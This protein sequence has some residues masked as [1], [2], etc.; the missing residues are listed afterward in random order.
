MNAVMQRIVAH[1]ERDLPWQVRVLRIDAPNAFCLPGGFIFFST[2]MLDALRSDAE[3][4]AIMAHEV[5]HVDKRHGMKQAARNQKLT[6]ASLAVIIATG[7]AGAPAI[8][9]QLAQTAITNS[10]GIEYEKQADKGGLEMLI[11]A[12]YPASAMVTVMEFFMSQEIKRPLYNYGIYM[13]H[14]E[15]VERVEYLSETIRRMNLP[16]ERKKALL[17]LRVRIEE[18]GDRLLL[19]VDEVKAWEG[20]NTKETREI[21]EKAREALDASFEMELA[22]YDLIV[23]EGDRLLR[24]ANRIVARAPLPQGTESLSSF[25]EKLLE[26]WN[27]ARKTHPIA[28]Y[29]Q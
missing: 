20:F 12:G 28:K 1:A 17:L 19:W 3:I 26:A 10:Y 22:P 13:T 5:T 27:A 18:K 11:A 2:G 16:L 4:A 8:A 9:A 14:P 6:L 21:F 24:V 29:F 23:E 7:G 25:R 15:S